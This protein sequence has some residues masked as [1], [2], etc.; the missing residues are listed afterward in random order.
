MEEE[1][2]CAAVHGLQFT[3][4]SPADLVTE[5]QQGST[6]LL[7]GLRW[8]SDECLWFLRLRHDLFSGMKNASRS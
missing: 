1:P 5:Q 7:S 2:W 3:Q 8:S 6:L 4:K